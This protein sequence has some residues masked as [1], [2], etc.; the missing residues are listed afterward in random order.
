MFYLLTHVI[1]KLIVVFNLGSQ[2]KKKK[3]K[4]TIFKNIGDIFQYKR[5]CKR[6][7]LFKLKVISFLRSTYL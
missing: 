1:Q 7:E 6:G 4:L 2:F 5:Y 3:K